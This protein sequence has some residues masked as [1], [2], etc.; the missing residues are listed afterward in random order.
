M[1]LDAVDREAAGRFAAALEG[2]GG[3]F[4]AAVWDSAADVEYTFYGLGTLALFAG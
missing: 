1:P 4:R 3:G 2:S